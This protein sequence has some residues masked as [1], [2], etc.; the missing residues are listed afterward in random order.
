MKG[1]AMRLS[2]TQGLNLF[3]IAG[4]GAMMIAAGMEQGNSN[5]PAGVDPMTTA[6]IPGARPFEGDQ[7]MAINHRNNSSCIIA[8]HRAEGYDVHR[9][10]PGQACATLDERMAQARA[11]QESP[12]GEVTVTD[13][14]GKPLM[15]LMRGDG[16]AWEVIKPGNL[17]VSFAAY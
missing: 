10:E 11:W 5:L 16:F 8:L 9:I 12:G 13:H 14:R 17:Q 2:P 4:I 6:S 15:T 7:F 3:A 1:P